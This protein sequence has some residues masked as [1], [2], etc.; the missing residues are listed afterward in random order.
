MQSFIFFIPQIVHVGASAN[1]VSIIK[2]FILGF[3]VFIS[4]LNY[5]ANSS[6]S[7]LSKFQA[8]KRVDLRH[9]FHLRQFL[10]VKWLLVI[11]V[12]QQ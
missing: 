1:P 10:K 9:V 3:H 5:F 11:V 4:F 2:S 12:Y 6:A 8:S 7:S